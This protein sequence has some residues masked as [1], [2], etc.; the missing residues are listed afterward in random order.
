MI[1]DLMEYAKYKEFMN[2][3]E[4]ELFELCTD[5]PEEYKK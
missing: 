1:K 3:Y 5:Y 4:D 2:A